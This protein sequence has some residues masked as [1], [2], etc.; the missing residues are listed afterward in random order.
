M[1]I[2]T[3]IESAVKSAFQSEI[4]NLFSVLS[5]SL[6]FRGETSKEEAIEKFKRGLGIAVESHDVAMRSVSEFLDKE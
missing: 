4:K 2:K 6:T 1:D 5:T 3:E